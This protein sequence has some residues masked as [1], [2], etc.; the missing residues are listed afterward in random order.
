MSSIINIIMRGNSS[1]NRLDRLSDVVEVSPPNGSA[2]VYN[3]ATDKYN[4][5]RLIIN[6]DDITDVDGGTF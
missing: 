1:S 5:E 2:L 6:A 3:S 4:V